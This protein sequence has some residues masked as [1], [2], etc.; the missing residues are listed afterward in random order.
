MPFQVLNTNPR[1]FDIHN[2]FSK[3]EADAFIRGAL[4]ETRNGYKLEPSVTGTDGTTDG[5]R[6][7]ETSFDVN[8]TLAIKIKKR[9]MATLGFDE[10]LEN[11]TDV[12]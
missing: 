3:E 8:S 4:A 6:T 12:S 7:S 10:F 5:T 2:F 11:F 1:V 9:C